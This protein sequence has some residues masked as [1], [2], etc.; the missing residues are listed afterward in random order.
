MLPSAP[1]LPDSL[2]KNVFSEN[3]QLIPR[4]IYKKDDPE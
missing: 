1:P 3:I 4:R 2:V